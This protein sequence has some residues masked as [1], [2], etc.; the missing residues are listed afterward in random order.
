MCL[1]FLLKTNE[2]FGQHNRKN[3]WPIQ[4]L[5]SKNKKT[6]LE[7]NYYTLELNTLKKS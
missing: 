7:E 6:E 4:H 5:F 1:L 3:I 2:H